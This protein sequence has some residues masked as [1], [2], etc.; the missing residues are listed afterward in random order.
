[1]REAIWGQ[2][3]DSMKSMK[4]IFLVIGH[5]LVHFI[6]GFLLYKK[7]EAG[8]T[9]VVDICSVFMKL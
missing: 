7:A 4:G 8:E 1:M 3:I 2:I 9:S 5:C 6:T